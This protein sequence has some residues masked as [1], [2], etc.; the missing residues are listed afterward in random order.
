MSKRIALLGSIA[1]L[2]VL[3][4]SSASAQYCCGGPVTVT[5]STYP[6][7]YPYPYPNHYYH[8]DNW[9][10][11]G[12]CDGPYNYRDYHRP[13]YFYGDYFYPYG[14]N[15][16]YHETSYHEGYGGYDD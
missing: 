6:S 12:C 9:W 16:H 14:Y 4:A 2:A 10:S 1:A 11:A 7:P 3:S 15:Y 5:V 13:L 8:R